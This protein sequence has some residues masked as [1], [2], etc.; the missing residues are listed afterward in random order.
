MTKNKDFQELQ[1]PIY[2]SYQDINYLAINNAYH[3]I[4]SYIPTTP[5]IKSHYLSSKY[6]HNIFLKLENLNIS[7]SFKIRGACHRILNSSLK[8]LRSS[9]VYATSAGNHAQGLAYMANK[10]DIK[11]TIFMPIGTPLIKIQATK[12]HGAQV[13]LTG[14]SYQESEEFAQKWNQDNHFQLI[15][16]FSDPLVVMGQGTVAIEIL[17]QLP[18][19]G[20][21]IAPVGGGGLISGIAKVIKDKHPEAQVIGVQSEL[22]CSV[23]RQ[24]RHYLC[25]SINSNNEGRVKRVYCDKQAC[26][27]HQRQDNDKPKTIKANGTLADGIAVKT[28]N[29]QCLDI[30]NNTVDAMICVSE[31][32]IAGSILELLERDHILCEGAAASTVAGLDKIFDN[33]NRDN[34]F[35][36]EFLNN[37]DPIVCVISGGNIDATVL[38]RITHKGL[39]QSYRMIKIVVILE[40][41]PG[42]LSKC[43]NIISENGA[44][45]YNIHHNRIFSNQGIRDV[46]VE[47][48]LEIANKEH[49]KSVLR[50]L[51]ANNY[52]I[53]SIDEK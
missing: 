39:S 7:G 24:F 26:V 18:N 2:N 3:Q 42:A 34:K 35:R 1:K 11:S 47:F 41:N 37:K 8:K 33:R 19:I 51:R 20:A 48:E 13:I 52:W 21:V 49:S 14:Q 16:A 6:N 4:K 36:N 40:D 53:K 43:L 45:L 32:Q 38:S 23:A 17:H 12:K 50:Q 9:G 10:L 25:N 5:L 30:I 44:N 22:C 29:K 15:H 31:H 27:E 28:P 46:E